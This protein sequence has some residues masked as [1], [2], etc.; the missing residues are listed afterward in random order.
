M[1]QQDHLA[2]ESETGRMTGKTEI[3]F[4]EA[5]I[6]EMHQQDHLA[7]ES[8]Y[9]GMTEIIDLILRCTSRII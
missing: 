9:D 3:S 4:I 7:R 8:E 5:K 1:H 2:R 6:Q